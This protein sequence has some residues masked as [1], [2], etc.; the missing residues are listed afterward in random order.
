MEQGHTW[1]AS[2]SPTI[3]AWLMMQPHMA[4][5]AHLAQLLCPGWE[6]CAPSLPFHLPLEAA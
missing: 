3:P 1:V 2:E 5:K 4:L 6:H